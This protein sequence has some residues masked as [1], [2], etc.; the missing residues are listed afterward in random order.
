[1]ELL[2]VEHIKKVYNNKPYIYLQSNFSSNDPLDVMDRALI[3]SLNDM[4][5][6]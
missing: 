5:P 3:N 2:P 1:M 4:Y 6:S